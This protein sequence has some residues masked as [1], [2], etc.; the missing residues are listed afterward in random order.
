[1]IAGTH[2]AGASVSRTANR[3]GVSRTTVFGVMTVYTNLG[4]VYSEKH[5]SGRKSK[6]KDRDIRGDDDRRPSSKHSRRS[7]SPYASESL[8][9]RTSQEDNAHVHT[10]RCVQTWLHGHDDENKVRAWFSPL[11]RR[12]DL[13]TAL[14]EE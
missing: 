14:Q 3:V 8:S 12:F 4:T 11:R 5:S 9:G 7:S 1:M 10:S 13:E 2:L 6:L